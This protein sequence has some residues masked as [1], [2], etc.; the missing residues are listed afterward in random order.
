ML[1]TVLIIIAVAT[2]VLFVQ[3]PIS[4]WLQRRR[5]IER[6]RRITAE[7]AREYGTAKPLSSEVESSKHQ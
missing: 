3:G 4:D 2:V 7:V 6:G 1:E 5:D